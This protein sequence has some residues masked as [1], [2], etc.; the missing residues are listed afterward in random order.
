MRAGE[1]ALGM[2]EEVRFERRRRRHEM[3]GI[4][5]KRQYVYSSGESI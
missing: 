5:L 4:W 1:V 3:N 2:A